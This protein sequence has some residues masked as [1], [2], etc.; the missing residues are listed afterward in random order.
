MHPENES[1][2][3]RP[4]WP[5]DCV[6]FWESYWSGLTKFRTPFGAFRSNY[7][8]RIGEVRYCTSLV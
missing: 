2:Y 1:I 7:P 3:I 5:D 4:I 6:K 8:R